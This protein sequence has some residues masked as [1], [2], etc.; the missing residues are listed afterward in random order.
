V[1]GLVLA[2][3]ILGAVCGVGSAALYEADAISSNTSANLGLASLALT[4]SSV[5]VGFAIRRRA[6]LARD[7]MFVGLAL[8]VVLN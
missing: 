2:V 3:A 8:P 1:G 4:A 5:A 6:S 7:G